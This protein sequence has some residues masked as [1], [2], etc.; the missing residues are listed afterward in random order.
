MPGIVPVHAEARDCQF[1][2]TPPAKQRRLRARISCDPIAVSELFGP[3][4]TASSKVDSRALFSLDF[5]G[6]KIVFDF[7]GAK[8]NP[9]CTRVSVKKSGPDGSLCDWLA[10]SSLRQDG[11]HVS[12]RL[13]GMCIF[14]RRKY[15]NAT[16]NFRLVA[17]R[18]NN[19]EICLAAR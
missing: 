11:L 3:S 14:D 5:G 12:K 8:I 19:Q 16:L 15:E 10:N 9:V 7:G 2:S 17:S 18:E 6:A 4:R 13:A 1:S